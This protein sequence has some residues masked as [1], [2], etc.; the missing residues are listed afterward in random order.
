MS[1]KMKVFAVIT[2]VIVAIA[3]IMGGVDG[4]PPPPVDFPTDTFPYPPGPF[5]PY[6]D[7]APAK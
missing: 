2:G 4:M 6:P 7:A 1:I 5:Y 3:V